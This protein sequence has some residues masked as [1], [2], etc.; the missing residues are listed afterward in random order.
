MTRRT[1]PRDLTG[2]SESV[3]LATGEIVWDAANRALRL[4]DSARP[5]GWVFVPNQGLRVR[6]LFDHMTVPQMLDVTSGDPQLDTANCFQELVDYCHTNDLIAHIPQVF[7]KL[8]KRIVSKTSVTI[9]CD[10][11][12]ILEWTDLA[13]CGWRVTGQGMGDRP[14]YCTVELPQLIGPNDISG[15]EG[16]SMVYSVAAFQ[17][18][19]FQVDDCIWSRYSVQQSKGWGT[20]V[21][22]TNTNVPTDNNRFELGTIDLCKYGLMVEC[23]AIA[24]K[25][26]GQSHIRTD[27]I[28]ALFPIYFKAP[29]GSPGVFELKIDSLGL[30][31]AETGG[32][33]IYH[34]GSDISDCRINSK[35]RNGYAANDSPAGTAT[36]MRGPIVGGDGVVGAEGGWAVGTRNHYRLHLDD[37]EPEAGDP[38]AVKMRGPGSRFEATAPQYRASNTFTSLALSTT[39]GEANFNS[40][41]GGAVIH[42]AT[43]VN[44]TVT[45][46][47]A[48]AS[49]TFYFY[50]QGLNADNIMPLRVAQ[51]DNTTSLIIRTENNGPTVPR[52]AKVIVFNPTASPITQVV[53]LWLEV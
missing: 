25:S 20:A 33:T 22:V 28:F 26:V 47:A 46:L 53:N 49:Q 8:G 17:G 14:G 51:I 10:S 27:N 32:T 9:T 7:A 18:V 48:G 39:Q 52:E 12:S 21:K 41:V 44:V 23:P 15:Y 3:S 43:R 4:G 2:A 37:F 6:S 24:T 38:I 11:D 5:G 35:A 29:S 36:D 1:I 16:G 19:G 31:V 30:T 50:H 34:E 42:A 13:D 45:A 40:G